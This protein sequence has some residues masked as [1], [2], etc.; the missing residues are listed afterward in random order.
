MEDVIVARLEAD[1]NAHLRT[2]GLA[3]RVG[4]LQSVSGTRR[5]GS[6]FSMHVVV[7]L[8]A[9]EADSVEGDEE[10]GDSESS[11][12]KPL[13]FANSGAVAAFVDSLIAAYPGAVEAPWSKLVDRQLY[14][15][16]HFKQMRL[17]GCTSF[18]KLE[19]LRWLLPQ[20][21]DIDDMTFE[22]FNSTLATSVPAGAATLV[23]PA[24]VLPTT[25][26]RKL[27]KLED[28][29]ARAQAQAQE[30]TNVAFSFGSPFPR[31]DSFIEALYLEF[32]PQARCGFRSV[33]LSPRGG[34]NWP[35]LH[36]QMYH[37][38]CSNI[39]RSHRSNHVVWIFDV[40]RLQWFQVCAAARPAALPPAPA[41]S[42]QH[43]AIRAARPCKPTLTRPSPPPFPPCHR[44]AWTGSVPTT[45]APP[46]RSLRP[47]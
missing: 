26:L 47:S 45:A 41:P 20:P 29:V 39:G 38:L 18:N 15:L 46:T 23:L 43:T 31:L 35:E 40:T 5:D 6:K 19:P 44:C 7:R 28:V 4:Q 36:F 24:D 8:V 32:V 14:S 3:A 2:L 11:P 27:A 25:P 9:G 37:G 12:P 17:V 13:A 30:H 42:R 21:V 10:A 1:L 16:A 33:R 34:V 22:Q